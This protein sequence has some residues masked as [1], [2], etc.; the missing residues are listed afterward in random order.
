MSNNLPKVPV[1]LL[2]HNQELIKAQ[3]GP[4]GQ[5]QGA[6]DFSEDIAHA[7]IS[8]VQN[9]YRT[10]IERA[11]GNPI[12]RRYVDGRLDVSYAADKIID[13]LHRV[14]NSGGVDQLNTE[15]KVALSVLFPLQFDFVPASMTQFVAS[16]NLRLAPFE[17]EQLRQFVASHLAE[18]LNWNAGIGGG[19][20]AGRSQT[21]S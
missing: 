1:R 15:E 11:N 13:A 10:P 3:E 5:R 14:K 4:A 18:E 7:E 16:V 8:G 19:S 12:F 20:T 6:T 17:V 9:T 21:H 2:E